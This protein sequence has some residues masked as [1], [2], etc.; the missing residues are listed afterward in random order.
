MFF[1]AIQRTEK[2][3][4]KTNKIKVS[5]RIVEETLIGVISPTEPKINAMLKMLEPI[6][7]PTASSVSPLTE[8]M[9]LVASSGRDVPIATM[10]R[11][12]RV[13]LIPIFLARNCAVVETHSAPNTTAPSPKIIKIRGEDNGKICL[14]V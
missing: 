10:V 12:T 7:F 11:P 5:I 13:S 3:V 9:T 2:I 14:Y 1:F 8:A 4:V 6:K